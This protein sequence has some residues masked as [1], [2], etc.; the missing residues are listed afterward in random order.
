MDT[1]NQRDEIRIDVRHEVVS[2]PPLV[3]DVPRR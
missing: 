1:P 3:T 2:A